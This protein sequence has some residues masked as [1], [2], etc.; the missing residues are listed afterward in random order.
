VLEGVYW[1][2]SQ[3]KKMAI[4]TYETGGSGADLRTAADWGVGESLHGRETIWGITRGKFYQNGTNRPLNKR[5]N[6][7]V[8]RSAR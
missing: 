1:A 7:S 5:G 6:R 3:G 8:V 4:S 2:D